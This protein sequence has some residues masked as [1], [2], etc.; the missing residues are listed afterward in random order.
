[1]LLALNSDN[2]SFLSIPYNRNR[3]AVLQRN[4]AEPILATKKLRKSQVCQGRITEMQLEV[5]TGGGTNTV[6][7]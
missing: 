7:N 5:S 4:L 3:H 2:Y 6:F 1:M